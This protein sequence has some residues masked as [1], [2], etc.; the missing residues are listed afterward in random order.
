MPSSL[1]SPLSVKCLHSHFINSLIYYIRPPQT[2]LSLSYIFSKMIYIV[3][4]F[5]KPRYCL[6]RFPIHHRCHSSSDPIHH[7]PRH[8]SQEPERQELY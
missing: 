8:G 4:I 5:P 2:C 3:T 6:H 7:C 1:P